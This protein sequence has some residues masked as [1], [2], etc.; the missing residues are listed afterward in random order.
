[1][2]HENAG[3][4]LQERLAELRQRM[5]G[6]QMALLERL[7]QE[8]GQPLADAV[9]RHY[10]ARARTGY[11]NKAAA[12]PRRD[13][14]AL[15][16]ILF[17]PARPLGIEYV[18]NEREDGVE[19]CVTKCPWHENVKAAREFAGD[20]G[21]FEWGYRMFCCTDPYIV[22]GFNPDWRFS[23]TKTLMQGHDCCNH[24]YH[25]ERGPK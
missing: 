18:V 3:D 8:F 9:E 21:E 20:A 7:K 10:G 25:F 14:D 15:L 17:E 12:L 16:K 4:E 22:E 5:L 24:Y 11:G 13:I 19:L 23:R 1:M 2:A 6:E